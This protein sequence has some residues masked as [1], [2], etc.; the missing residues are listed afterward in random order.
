M[1]KLDTPPPASFLFV[2]TSETINNISMGLQEIPT[3]FGAPTINDLNAQL[4]TQQHD[5]AKFVAAVEAFLAP[6][7][8]K[9]AAPK[10]PC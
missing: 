7:K 2:L 5:P 6:I 1:Q 9:L 4:Q 10:E 3:K 8:A